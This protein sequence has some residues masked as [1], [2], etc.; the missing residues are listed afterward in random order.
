MR[1]RACLVALCLFVLPPV[2]GDPPAAVS[3]EL[4]VTERSL[5]ELQLMKSELHAIE[6][7]LDALIASLSERRG[8]LQ[9]AKPAPFGGVTA[10]TSSVADRPDAKPATLRCAALTKEGLRCSRAALPGQRYCRQHALAKQK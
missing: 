9:N 3:E 5:A 7:R 1:K 2:Q 4:Q 8:Q 10:P 6:A